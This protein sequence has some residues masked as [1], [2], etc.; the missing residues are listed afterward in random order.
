MEGV[1]K[2]HKNKPGNVLMEALDF[3]EDDLEA[4]RAGQLSEVQYNNMYS[5]RM[6]FIYVFVTLSTVIVF[7]SILT[8]SLNL[9]VMATAI[10]FFMRMKLHQFDNDLKGNVLPMEGVVKLDVITNKIHTN[11]S[12]GVAYSIRINDR[13]LNVEKKA[14]LAFKNGD[15]YRIYFTPNTKK[16]LSAEW[17][18][19][20]QDDNYL[21]DENHDQETIA[22]SISVDAGRRSDTS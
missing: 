3:D 7:M 21:E 2:N 10:I 18:Y 15:P 20:V 17:L 12:S 1:M 4:N 19:D 16:I 11:V 5:K 6:V 13:K 9:F 8:L 14:F 22:P